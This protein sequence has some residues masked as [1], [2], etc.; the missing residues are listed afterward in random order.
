[1]PD[2]FPHDRILEATPHTGLLSVEDAARAAAAHMAAN[3]LRYSTFGTLD[4]THTTAA[5]LER[6]VNAVPASLV[7]ALSGHIYAFV[8]LALSAARLAGDDAGFSPDD[9]TLIAPRATAAL[10]EKAT[11]HRNSSI[12]GSEHVFLSARLHSDRFALAFEFFI[13]IAHNF[14][15]TLDFSQLGNGTEPPRNG[16]GTTAA[17]NVDTRFLDFAGLVWS[18]A[19]ANVRGETSIDAFE[20]RGEALGQPHAASTGRHAKSSS[21]AALASQAGRVLDEKARTAY[22]E[23]AFSDTLAIYLLSLHLDFDYADLRERDYPL[24][25]PAALADRLRLVNR[26]FPANAGYEFSIRYRRNG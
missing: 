17:H 23:T 6:L 19:L 8:P 25:A 26:I 2:T 12:G 7:P 9:R 11:C 3:G 14:T 15:D 21:G 10:I 18:Q 22:L 16:S 1:M 24:L 20:Q 5:E 4:A 13:N